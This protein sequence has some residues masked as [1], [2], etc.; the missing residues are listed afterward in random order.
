MKIT[1][2]QLQ[3]IIVEERRKL[4]EAETFRTQSQLDNQD[5]SLP[6]ERIYNTVH[7]E[8][9][10]VIS[11]FLTAYVEGGRSPGL[12]NIRS[13]EQ[14]VPEAANEALN[15]ALEAVGI[16]RRERDD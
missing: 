10:A 15:N 13:L 5:P 2:R 3:R 11:D 1:K 16:S 7:D 12:D 14:I 4:H 9:L 6:L 8:V